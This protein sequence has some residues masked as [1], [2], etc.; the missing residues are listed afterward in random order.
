MVLAMAVLHRHN[1]A[2]ESR[3]SQGVGREIANRGTPGLAN[4]GRRRIYMDQGHDVPA[5]DPLAERRSGI[6]C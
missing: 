4:D 2:I 3:R 1:F 5:A 6:V